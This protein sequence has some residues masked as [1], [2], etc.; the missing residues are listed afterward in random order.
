MHTTYFNLQHFA[1]TGT[2]VNATGN[3]V[4]VATGATTAFD[5]GHSLSAELK[6]F[7]DTELL[8]NAR[9][10]LFYA[11]FPGRLL[12]LLPRHQRAA[13]DGRGGVSSGHD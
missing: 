9:T 13:G 3:F 1:E 11:Q 8:E 2:L 10:E 5:N 6:A 4:N 7:Y 12:L